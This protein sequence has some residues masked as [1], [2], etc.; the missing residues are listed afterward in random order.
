ME[1]VVREIRHVTDSARVK[2]LVERDV[3]L[4]TVQ[5]GKMSLG[6]DVILQKLQGG[7]RSFVRDVMLQTVQ[8]VKG[9]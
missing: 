7:K 4:Q 9:P 6:R 2:G 3:M 1:G 8:G 5:G